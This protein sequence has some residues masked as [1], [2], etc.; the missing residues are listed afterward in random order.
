MTG[1]VGSEPKVKEVSQRENKFIRPHFPLV[2]TARCAE[3]IHILEITVVEPEY[4]HSTTPCR[5][6]EQHEHDHS[7]THN[8]KGYTG[9]R[10]R[11]HWR[12]GP[13]KGE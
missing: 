9:V 11:A 12:T 8:N 3:P 2:F 7:K 1:E 13:L 4:V 6:D 5:G 10:K